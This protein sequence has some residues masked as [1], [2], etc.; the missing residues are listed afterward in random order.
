MANSK[1]SKKVTKNG[2]STLILAPKLTSFHESPRKRVKLGKCHLQMT[3]YSQLKTIKG[4]RSIQF[5][6]Q[7][8]VSD[9]TTATEAVA[10]P[11]H[12][13]WTFQSQG[14]EETL[15]DFVQLINQLILRDNFGYRIIHL[16]ACKFHRLN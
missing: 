9:K 8:V 14:P 3:K 11:C 2:S 6:I 15:R 7:D 12:P 1:E 5:P 4:S 16:L 10:R 13:I